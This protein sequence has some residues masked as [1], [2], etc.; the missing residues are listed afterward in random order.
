[1]FTFVSG[2]LT[3]DF[4]GTVK[5]RRSY[6]A[7]LL[8]TPADLGS[9]TIA[10]GLLDR[11]PDCDAATLKQG[12]RLREA[13]YRM[14][15]AAMGGPAVADADRALVNSLA[16]GPL[17]EITLRADGGVRRIG[18]ADSA[19]AEIAR[20]AVELFGGPDRDRIKECGRPE[21]TRLYID[22]S[23][24]GSRRWCDMTVCGNRAKSAAF[25]ARHTES[26]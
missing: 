13:V 16:H 8:E 11:E 24:G 1:M 4:I 6:A 21:C 18:D 5:G 2:N 10:A 22:T 15:L 17:P 7:D 20:S 3:L 12:V 14:A 19:L 26:A 9:W 23:R 25:R